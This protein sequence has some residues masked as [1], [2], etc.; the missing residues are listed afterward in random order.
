MLPK[1]SAALSASRTAML[2]NLERFD[3]SWKLL[4]ETMTLVP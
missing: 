2:A 1:V 3:G 4:S